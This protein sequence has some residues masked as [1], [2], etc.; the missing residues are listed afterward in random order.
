[1]GMGV[2]DP[3]LPDIAKNLGANNWEVELLFSTYIFMMALIMIPAGILATRIGDKNVMT[4]GLLIVSFFAIVVF[5]SLKY[6][7]F[8]LF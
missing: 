7:N 3:I 5:C 1:M 2:V 8:G 4:I 6:Y